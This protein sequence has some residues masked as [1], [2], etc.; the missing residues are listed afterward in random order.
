ML[1]ERL[2]VAGEDRMGHKV[3]SSI[4]NSKAAYAGMI[5]VSSIVVFL[6]MTMSCDAQ[7]LRPQH[8][9]DGETLI[10]FVH[11]FRDDGESTWTNEDTKASW[12]DMLSEDGRF[13]TVD[14]VTF[15]YPSALTGQLDLSVSQIAD[16][17]DLL[18]KGQEYSHY[19]QIVF[20]AHSMGGLVV[21][22][23]LLKNRALAARVPMIMFLATPTAGSALADY[24]TA[25]G[26]RRRQLSA[27]QTLEKSNFLEDQDSQWR[28]W[29][30]SSGIFSFCAY[31]T[32]PTSGVMVVTQASAQSLCSGQTLPA[33]E[34]HSG[35]AK[36]ASMEH[37]VYKTFSS[38]F[39]QRLNNVEESSVAPLRPNQFA[40]EIWSIQDFDPD[41]DRFK[42]GSAVAFSPDGS[43]LATATI[44]ST[45]HPLGKEVRILD[46]K[47]GKIVRQLRSW[48][49]ALID[50]IIFSPDGN[51]IAAAQHDQVVKW[52]LKDED[53][54]PIGFGMGDQVRKI[55]F[56]PDSRLLGVVEDSGFAHVILPNGVGRRYAHY[57]LEDDV[58]HGASEP[59]TERLGKPW[60]MVF[61]N[62]GTQ[63]V[64]S[65]SEGTLRL[66]DISNPN[67]PKAIVHTE[68][69]WQSDILV[70]DDD[71]E[72]VFGSKLGLGIWNFA[73][74]SVDF[75]GADLGSTIW[76]DNLWLDASNSVLVFNQVSGSS[77][78]DV[79]IVDMALGLVTNTYWPRV[80]TSCSSLDVSE[81]GRM[82]AL[83]CRSP[84]FVMLELME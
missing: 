20:V 37:I 78:G 38:S 47:S 11:G 84:A 66:W 35:I 67:H 36:P 70:K 18:L 39:L 81:S 51:T 62:N 76:A 65:S 19:S 48:D 13:D 23:M 33:P 44:T 26:L 60:G 24:S 21:R 53:P 83:A 58:E 63:F 73:D 31:E 56:S 28:S 52:N 8:L 34:N 45:D 61:L 32:K 75:V 59:I 10:V 16:Q 9:R 54:I 17:L 5:L 3:C 79:H 30:E 15:H 57:V 74:A 71:S 50:Q 68:A 22:N 82:V 2:E 55:A 41:I 64:T 12:P 49:S 29:Q 46:S 4:W 77:Q 14:I 80:P 40:Q 72:A 6:G 42:W 69:W 43:L 27:L 1:K 25:F 7:E